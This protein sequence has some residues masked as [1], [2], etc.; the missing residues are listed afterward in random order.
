MTG[1]DFNSA[2]DGGFVLA[3]IM[4][5]AVISISLWEIAKAVIPHIHLF[6]S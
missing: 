3:L 5:I 2:G 1:S 4:L 6:W